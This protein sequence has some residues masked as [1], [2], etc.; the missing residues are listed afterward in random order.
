MIKTPPNW[1]VKCLEKVCPAYLLDEI[2]GDFYE[3]YAHL[4]ESKSEKYANRK[5]F[6]FLLLSA[7]RLILQR[8]YHQPTSID[9]LRNYFLIAIRN[10]KRQW[11]YSLINILGLAVGLACCMLI[12]IYVFHEL[13]Y[14]TFNEKKEKLFRVNVTYSSSGRS[15]KM[16][17]TPTA[18]LPTMKREFTEVKEGVR[19]F[20]VSQ[21]S[22]VIVQKENVKYQEEQFLYVDST[23]FDVFSFKLTKGNPTTCLVK[24]NSLVI[25]EES[26]AK[27]FAEE[28]PMGEVVKV[29]GKDYTITG[30]LENLPNNSHIRFDFL[31]SFS[32]L[33]AS[34]SE[35]WFSAN[36]ATYVEIS[37]PEVA[38]Q[39]EDDITTAVNKMLGD[40]L[41]DTTID[42]ELMPLTDIHLKSDVPN[43]MQPQSDMRYIYII[44]V[45][46]LLILVIACINY[47][48]LATARSVERSREV[49]MRKVLGAVRKQLFYQFMGE[50]AII[51]LLAMVIALI[52]VN[53]SI[54]PFNQLTGKE[55]STTD[56]FSTPMLVGLGL[57][58]LIVTF[59]AGAYP[60]ITLSSFT[61]S[62]V[63]K[64][65]FTRSKTGSLM[66]KVL[67][68]LQ[69]SISI[70]LII[71]TLVIYK[72]LNFMRDKKLGYDKENVIILPTD[73]E[74]NKNFETIKTELEKREDVLSVS[75]ASESPTDIN[76]GYSIQIP[77]LLDQSMSVNAVTVDKSFLETMDMQ[78]VSG[79]N[80]TNTDHILAI[81]EKY[82][83]R[84]YAFIVNQ[85]LVDK[86]LQDEQN[87]L[88]TTAS[89]NGREGEIVGVVEDF[90]FTSLHRKINPLVLFIEP[91]QFNK[92]FIRIKSQNLQKTLVGIEEQC[93]TI[94]PDRP[95]I[96]QFMDDEYAA[97]YR[98]EVRLSNVFTVF[99]V[100]AIVIACLGLFGL[101]SFAVE[102]RNKE[103][104]VRKVLGASIPSLFFLISK[105]FSKLVLIAFLLAA[106]IGYWL[107][108][109]WLTDFEYRT[110]IGV[111]PIVV[112]V[113][114]AMM[115]AYITV[116]Y[117]SIKAA[118]LNP[119]ETL[120][121]E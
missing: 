51:T 5:A 40:K 53:I 67:V 58:F 32:S 103:I 12:G 77:S 25:T 90:H 89:L 9:M 85:E 2:V 4:A 101:V 11:G 22:P 62:K 104:G 57:V 17:M 28:D 23:F 47:M 7:P 113:V 99:A 115:V 106:P 36:Y 69:F 80:F 95:F 50:S 96:F 18:L 27:Y 16:F 14:D 121:T 72:Q 84:K 39:L 44:S 110:S 26:A 107:M 116:S 120:R 29:D 38:R 59:L 68:V 102:Q 64:G 66:R 60:A 109:Q 15:G 75:S 81:K 65:R 91:A 8:R 3:R 55:L 45:V 30:V 10:I 37:S 100:L 46:G 19:V 108:D 78:L 98:N 33:R 82:E 118:L 6:G 87:I 1:I 63:L 112:S 94:V 111:L 105:D 24:P 48:N 114:S 70:F 92:L 49:G 88:G 13:S 61:P 21:F 97:M 42:F 43:E 83:E 35:I 71:G 34:Q 79:R 117:Q 86:L 76:G 119:A 41:G 74:V 31:A 73:R 20:N 93:K 52:V 54:V 56:V